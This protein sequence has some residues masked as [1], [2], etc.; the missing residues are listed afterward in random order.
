[1]KGFPNSREKP[2]SLGAVKF[3]DELDSTECTHLIKSLAYCKLPFQCAH[4]RPSLT[5]LVD[6]SHLQSNCD[7]QTSK[8]QLWKI[9]KKLESRQQQIENKYDSV[10][11]NS[12]V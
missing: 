3:G 9:K 12:T 11:P 8:P 2:F 7:K 10:F 5:P 4:G 6:F 1:M